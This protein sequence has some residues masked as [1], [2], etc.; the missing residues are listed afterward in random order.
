MKTSIKLLLPIAAVTLTTLASASERT[1]IPA[2]APSIVV[3]YDAAA[4]VSRK[5][6]KSLH[7]RLYM[8]AQT[9]CKQLESRELG[10]REQHDQCVRDAV[11]RSVADVGNDNLTNYHRYGSLPRQVAAN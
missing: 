1:A 2:N 6:V 4:L 7:S 3:Q 5:A 9:V 8:A 11:K 10:L